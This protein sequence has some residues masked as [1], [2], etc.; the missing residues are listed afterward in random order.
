LSCF[1][2]ALIKTING[3]TGLQGLE[4]NINIVII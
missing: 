2:A 3:V 1:Y 4:G